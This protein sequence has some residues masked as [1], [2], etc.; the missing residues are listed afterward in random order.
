LDVL[1]ETGLENFS[2]RQVAKKLRVSP[3]AVFAHCEGSL[4]GL[5]GAMV[6]A[7]L[8]DVARPYGPDDSPAGYVRDLFLSLLNAIHSKQPLAQLI[9]IELSTDP[10]VCPIFV[11]RVLSVALGSGK[12]VSNPARALDLVLAMLLGMIMMEGETHTA[13]R[14]AGLSRRFSNRAKAYPSNEVPTLLA[15]RD[16]LALQ[17][18][19]RLVASSTLLVR[20]AHW[21]AEPV[22]AALK[23]KG[24]A[25]EA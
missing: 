12:V 25:G 7:V 14:S 23:L 5:K 21:Y 22:I 8:R 2:A 15:N 19:R 17:I 9:A 10:L 24:G 18:R 6:N 3:A 1:D 11:E 20:T 16:D 13:G 4:A